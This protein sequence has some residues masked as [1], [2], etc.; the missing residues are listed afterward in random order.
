[1]YMVLCGL[2]CQ[3]ELSDSPPLDPETFPELSLPCR[4]GAGVKETL[5][6]ECQAIKI[7][8]LEWMPFLETLL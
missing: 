1:M 3:K 4:G 8:A 7:I 6:L 5:H 2:T